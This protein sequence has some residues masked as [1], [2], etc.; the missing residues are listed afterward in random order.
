MFYWKKNENVRCRL[1]K[2]E[3]VKSRLN[4]IQ[5]RRHCSGLGDIVKWESCIRFKIEPKS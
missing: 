3:N 2:N 4:E 5:K 1:K